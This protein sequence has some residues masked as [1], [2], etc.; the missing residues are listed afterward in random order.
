MSWMNWL[1]AGAAAADYLNRDSTNR[2]NDARVQEAL[3]AAQE[4][5]NNGADIAYD[6][7]ASGQAEAAAAV[8]AGAEGAA[9]ALL[10][11]YGV[12]EAVQRE[13]YQ[14][15]SEKLQ[16]FV[17]LGISA[18]DEMAS[19]LGIADSKG[20]IV[21]Y[22]LRKLEDTPGYQFQFDQGTKAVQRSQVGRQLSGRAAKELVGY[23]QGLAQQYFN[24]R[25]AQLQSLGQFGANAASNQAQAALSTGQNIGQGALNT[26]ANL[27][28]VLMDEGGSLANIA[29]GAAAN[30]ANVE[31]NRSEQLQNT[32][33][34]GA[35][36]ANESANQQA[37][38]F[39]NLLTSTLPLLTSMGSNSS[40]LN[41]VSTTGNN[42]MRPKYTSNGNYAS[43]LNTGGV[44]FGPY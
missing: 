41:R 29:T 37:Q 5:I 23:G 4:E 43:A 19:M 13:F 11:W 1:A 18:F 15:A 12:S 7:I 6:L 44:R 42:L 22:D 10:E 8:I 30:K 34:T 26:G 40:T 21:P 35:I 33:L 2:K 14:I 27:A 32:Q 28:R 31:Q 36:A 25:L 39:S 16:P 24:T 9:E 17:Q 3:A 20:Q 38:G